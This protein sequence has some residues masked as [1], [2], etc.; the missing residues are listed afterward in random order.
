MAFPG[1][2]YHQEQNAQYQN[3]P[4]GR[5]APGPPAYQNVPY[6]QS[7]AG[8][9]NPYGQPG[10]GPS[11][12][13]PIPSMGYG[14][15]A[16]APPPQG[17]GGY[18]E[19]Q[20]GNPDAGFNQHYPNAFGEPMGPPPNWDTR[21]QYQGPSNPEIVQQQRAQGFPAPHAPPAQQQSFGIN[22]M[23]FQYGNLQGKKKALLVGINYFG[24][25]SE[26]H[27]CI[28]DVHN[29]VTF[30][31][32]RYGFAKDD[33]V[34]LTD[35]QT[36]PKAIP[37]RQNMLG[38]M[39]W[40]VSDARPNDNLFF[41]YSGHGGRTQDLDGDEE[42]GYDECIYP[43]D[44]KQ[45]QPGYIL[46][47]EIHDILVRSLPMGCRLTGLFDCC[48]SGSVMDLPY[49]YSTKGV[50]KEPNL[51]KDAGSG[52]LGIGQAYLRNDFGSVVSGASGLFKKFTNGNS[53]R[54]QVKAMKTAPAD[55]ICF[56]GCKDTQ[57]SADASIAGQGQGAMSFAFRN[58]LLKNPQQSYLQL[59]NSVRQEMTQG[60]YEQ[61]PQLACCHPLDVN[62]LFLL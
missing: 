23:N 8:Y 13:P 49:M 55:V 24:T 5:A 2:K 28:N 18:N 47:D 37:T 14:A 43:V 39:Q 42:D 12:G 7:A 25:D 20:Q 22:G 51:L 10:Y 57:T 35:D 58:A 16:G 11:Q 4:Y 45:T 21:P 9:P 26:L 15:Q 17:Y 41:H 52:M 53:N 27:G 62:L 29:M 1:Q 46:D 56:T 54:D 40:L 59:L 60:G 3:D 44:F 33:M 19:Y 48:H 30:L 6:G 31:S 61:K 34:I 50:L 36:H 32:E 38:A